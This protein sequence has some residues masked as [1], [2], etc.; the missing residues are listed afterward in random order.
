MRAASKI[1]PSAPGG[2]ALTRRGPRFV[3]I[4]LPSALGSASMDTF[5]GLPTRIGTFIIAA[6]ILAF[7]VVSLLTAVGI[8]IPLVSGPLHSTGNGSE[9]P[10]TPGR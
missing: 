7:F 3:A 4:S 2:R 9:Q 6:L 1:I 10:L 5:P 8:E